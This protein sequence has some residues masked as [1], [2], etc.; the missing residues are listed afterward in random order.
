MKKIPHLFSN[1]Q[2]IPASAV[3]GTSE[4]AIVAM[5]AA[6]NVAMAEVQAQMEKVGFKPDPDRIP[7][8]VIRF[9]RHG[10]PE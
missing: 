1:E 6:A 9:E 7:S 10:R 5:L 8:I 2:V 3:L 4:D